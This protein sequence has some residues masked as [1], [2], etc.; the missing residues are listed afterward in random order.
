MSSRYSDSFVPTTTFRFPAYQEF[1][2]TLG[3]A[4]AAIEFSELAI[5][6]LLSELHLS[7]QKEAFIE[8]SSRTFGVR[9]NSSNPRLIRS[10]TSNLH[11]I[12]VHQQFELF[13]QDFRTQATHITWSKSEGDSWLYGIMKAF[14]G[15]FQQNV[16][17]IGQLE[18][19]LADY[20]RL[21]RNSF[22]HTGSEHSVSKDVRKLRA[23]AQATNKYAKLDAPNEQPEINFDDFVLYSR[24]AKELALGLCSAAR[25]SDHEIADMIIDLEA[26][27][28][29]NFSLS[30]IRGRKVSMTRGTNKLRTVLRK[31]YGLSQYEADPIIDILFCGP[32]AQR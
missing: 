21:V 14:P 8:S 10:L 31:I 15:G 29:G 6:K 19:E 2:R 4:D 20:Y 3:R 13:L 12:S 28:R 22:T 11:L 26:E 24:V 32:L 1:K 17:K 25:P 27:K 23:R 9:V 7:S 30:D 16:S 5:R 18:Y